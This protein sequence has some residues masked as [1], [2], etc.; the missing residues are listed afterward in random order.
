M[1]GNAVTAPIAAQQKTWSAKSARRM[2][3]PTVTRENEEREI[4]GVLGPASFSGGVRAKFLK[5]LFEG[6]CPR[7]LFS[8]WDYFPS[9]DNHPE[10]SGR[11]AKGT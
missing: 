10:T 1:R 9:A 7:R 11:R 2:K 8:G 4:Q 5:A 6:T 3:T